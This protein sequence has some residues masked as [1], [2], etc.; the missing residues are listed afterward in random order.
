[1]SELQLHRICNCIISIH[2]LFFL[3]PA[4][5]TAKYLQPPD[6][7]EV[8]EGQAA[9]FSC[10]A[11]DAQFIWW[12]VNGHI[13]D[14][15]GFVD[16]EANAVTD[17][18]DKNFA[19]SFSNLTLPAN[20]ITDGARVVCNLASSSGFPNPP[21]EDFVLL[22]VQG[23]ALMHYWYYCMIIASLSLQARTNQFVIYP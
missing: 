5:S 20:D 22:R 3:L 1:M 8:A 7:V 18:D 14:S 15:P 11:E 12:T 9:S 13:Q 2:Q 19:I 23:T 4:G 21:A 16:L 10:H 6:A 17:H